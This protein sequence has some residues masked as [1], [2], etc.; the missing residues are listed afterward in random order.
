ME[1]SYKDE[2]MQKVKSKYEDSIIA[3]S[4]IDK[5]EANI[6]E[7][8]TVLQ[9]NLKLE[10]NAEESLEVVVDGN[11]KVYGI[12]MGNIGLYFCRINNVIGV[13]TRW[14]DDTKDRDWI[15]YDKL[16]KKVTNS[17]DDEFSI[18]LL[19]QYL[20]EQF[21]KFLSKS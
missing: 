13:K 8:F 14:F 11:N 15:S 20:K 4:Y 16:H 12:N 1:F 19:E 7:F 18:E 5:T 6:K 3:C 10:I 9:Y 2:F 17:Q 21:D